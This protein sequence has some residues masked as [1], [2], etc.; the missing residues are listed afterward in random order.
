MLCQQIV[1]AQ[2]DTAVLGEHAGQRLQGE[3]GFGR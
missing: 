1:P 2:F 3:I